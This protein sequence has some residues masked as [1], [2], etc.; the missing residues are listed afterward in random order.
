MLDSYRKL[1]DLLDAR[2]RR[3]ALLVFCLLMGVAL[4]EAA[5]VASILPFMVVLSKPNVVTTNKLLSALYNGLEFQS[6]ESFLLFL[7]VL[8]FFV[9]IGAL[10]TRALGFFVQVRFTSARNHALAYRLVRSYLH[11]PYHFFLNRHSSDLTSKILQEVAQAVYGAM[12]PAMQMVANALVVTCLLILIVMIDPMLAITT[13]VTLGGAYGIIVLLGRRR[14]N[15][16]GVERVVANKDRYQVIQEAFGGIKDIKI[17]G[18]EAVFLE[19]FRGPSQKMA[20]CHVTAKTIGELPAFA[21][22]ALVFGGMLIVLLY[23]MFSRGGLQ[24]ALP[25]VA[26]YAFAGYRLMPALQAIYA[27]LSEFRFNQ[28]ALQALHADVQSLQPVEEGAERAAADNSRIRLTKELQ[29]REVVFTYPGASQPALNGVTLVVPARTKVGLVG[30]SGSGKTTSVDVM[31]GLLRPD[32]GAI[33]VD[34]TA[35]TTENV[36]AWQRNIGYVP[37]Q[38][39]ITDASVAS[40]IA[41][42][43]PAEQVD[44]NAV[45]RAARIANLHEFVVQ[46]LDNGYETRLGEHGVRLSGGQRQR[47]GIAR[48]LYHDPDVLIMDEATSALDNLTERAVMEAVDNLGNQKTIVLIAHRLTTV[49]SCDRIYLM[50]RGRVVASGSYRELIE[51]NS[52]FRDMAGEG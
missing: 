52:T 36:R 35:I 28:A 44:R 33:Q 26:V 37:Q 22:Q 15:R 3:L 29:F 49:Q 34:D 17:G 46:E 47:I 19:R 8:M 5:G 6:Q 12:F 32:S 27:Q 25:T 2:E 13:F 4:V 7:G 16:A 48:A 40:N 41:F 43:V 24:E 30:S 39:Y 45:E 21:M 14:L 31:L 50:E 11:Q 42:G 23:L 9:L 51:S 20:H 10:A 1:Y 38:I 18:L